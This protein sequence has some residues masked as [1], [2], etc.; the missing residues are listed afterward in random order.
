[1]LI[2]I[3]SLE[4]GNLV[5]KNLFIYQKGNSIKLRGGYGNHRKQH[6]SSI[7]FATTVN[8][9]AGYDFNNELAQGTTVVS[10]LD[11]N[12]NWEETKQQMCY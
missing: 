5:T 7:F 2:F 11:P 9:F 3:H 12:V 6:Y 8:G 10:A 1:M 4:L